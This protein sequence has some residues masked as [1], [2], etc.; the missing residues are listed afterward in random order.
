MPNIMTNIIDGSNEHRLKTT[1]NFTTTTKLNNTQCNC[2]Q[3]SD[4]PLNNK[5]LYAKI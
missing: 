4:C 2:K 1:H 5:C 3:P